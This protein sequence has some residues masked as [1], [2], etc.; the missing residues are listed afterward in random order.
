M[1]SDDEL[2]PVAERELVQEAGDVRLDS[3]GGDDELVGDLTVGQPTGDEAED[4]ELA[5]AEFAERSRMIGARRPMGV[6]S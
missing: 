3:R 2:D 1:G 6:R 5:G 4:V